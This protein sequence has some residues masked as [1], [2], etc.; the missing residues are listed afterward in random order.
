MYTHTSAQSIRAAILQ[1]TNLRN[2]HLWCIACHEHNVHLSRRPSQTFQLLSYSN[3][4]KNQE[5]KGGEY[6]KE[7]D[8]DNKQDKLSNNIKLFFVISRMWS[9]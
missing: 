7:T 5:E 4:I 1:Y 9:P 3:L 2:H 8:V 6:Y